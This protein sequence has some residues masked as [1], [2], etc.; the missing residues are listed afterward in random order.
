[1]KK[2]L[3]LLSCAVALTMGACSQEKTTDTATTNMEGDGMTTTTT[4]T[5]TTMT[6]AMY[7]KEAVESRADRMAADMATKMKLDEAMRTKVR[8]VYVN[9][10]MRM[11]ELANKYATDTTG[12][13][14]DMRNVYS[15]SDMEMKQVFVDPAMY[16]QYETDRMSYYDT[17][18]MDD[19]SMSAD[20]SGSSDASMDANSKTKYDDGSKVK[21]KSDG[22]IKIKD[23]EGNK[24]KMDA[25]DGTVKDKPENGDKTVIK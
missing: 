18:Y 3:L 6:P 1:M 16:T 10:G 4:T 13:A 11:S 22:D 19:T 8:T 20:A 23:A 2:T 21:V 17:N 9:R 25:D 5:T 7:T 24:T 12:M 15:E 14:A